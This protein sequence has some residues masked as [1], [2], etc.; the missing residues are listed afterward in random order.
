[1]RYDVKQRDAGHMAEQYSKVQHFFNQVG[2]LSFVVCAVYLTT[3]FVGEST[4]QNG[5]WLVSALVLG[6]FLADFLTGLVHWGCDTWGNADTFFWGRVFIRSFREH[7]VVPTAI[8][9]HDWAQANGEQSLVGCVI[10]GTIIYLGPEG[11]STG[12]LFFQALM[13]SMIAFSV[14]TNQFHKWSHEKDP[15]VLARFFIRV[16]FVQSYKT[17]MKHHTAPYENAYCITT[18]WMNPLL[19]KIRFFR[20]LEWAIMRITGALPRG[21]DVGEWAALQ[22]LRDMGL[23]P[24]K[25]YRA[26]YE[27]VMREERSEERAA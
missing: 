2:V 10:L 12:W 9:E 3:V 1:V 23:T 14:A 11:E 15:S 22:I 17:H 7:H 6:I 13:A 21:D 8:T 18:G 4:S 24:P 25:K 5:P 26:T 20:G 16:G 19:D 27:A